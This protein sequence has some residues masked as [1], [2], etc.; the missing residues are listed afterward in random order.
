[1]SKIRKLLSKFKKNRNHEDF[2]HDIEEYNNEEILIDSQQRTDHNSDQHE[3][4]PQGSASSYTSENTLTSDIAQGIDLNDD[5]SWKDSLQ[6]KMQRVKDFFNR[7]NPKNFRKIELSNKQSGSNSLRTKLSENK[8]PKGLKTIS[9]NQLHNSL[10]SPAIRT[11]INKSF[12]MVMI[13]LGLYLSTSTISKVLSGKQDYKMISKDSA[14]E[15]DRSK[16][17]TSSNLNQIKMAKVFQT[18]TAKPVDP[19]KNNK[20]AIDQVLICNKASKKTR[21]PIKLINTIVLQDTVKSIASVQI[22]STPPLSVREGDKIENIAEVGKIDR[23]GMII[24]NLKEGTCEKV[25]SSN[26]ESFNRKSS[27]SVMT[28]S[29]SKTFK[30]QQ[31]SVKGIEN[32]GNNFKV[33]K[34]FLQEKMSD[35][36]NILTQARGI[37]INNPDGSLSFKIVDIEPGGIFSYLGIQ[38]NDVITSINGKK[39]NDL[40]EVMGLF[41]KIT[42]LDQLN[43][44][45]TRG[46]DQVPLEYKFK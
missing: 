3:N 22:R 37:Q 13:M 4:S 12:Q 26:K 18:D 20:P 28:P 8:I 25:E 17:L 19:T 41:S 9:F 10:F 30:R 15:I 27:I 1:M 24:K 34:S 36:S 2:N 43:L 14:V 29:Q 35:I 31:T 46:G 39:I 32:E 16:E 5:I 23:M 45:V 6:L 7:L 33:D 11:P 38:D 44:T 42:T 21:L 40:N